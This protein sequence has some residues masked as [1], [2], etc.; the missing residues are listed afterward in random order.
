MDI[1]SH[2]SQIKTRARVRELAEVYTHEREVRAMLDLV[3][4]A[5]DRVDSKF[6][7]PACGSGNFVEEILR[8][9]LA[10]VRVSAVGDVHEYEHMLLRAVASIYALDICAEN[11]SETR[12]RLFA[13]VRSHYYNDA[14]T[15]EP[16]QGFVD[17]LRAILATNII[18]A[19]FLSD[20]STVELIDYRPALGQQF[21]R[22]W[23]ILDESASPMVQPDLFHQEPEERADERPVHYSL[24]ASHEEPVRDAYVPPE[25]EELA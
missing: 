2:R 12:D 25:I 7:E 10:Q 4:D 23:S 18:R 3:P 20:G 24:L 17:A 13:E 6:L 16:T 8:R 1:E 14:N 15:V 19:D 5:F 21:M 22:K 11:V 9:K